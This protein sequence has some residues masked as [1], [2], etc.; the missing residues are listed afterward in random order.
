[1]QVEQLVLLQVLLQGGNG[2]CLPGSLGGLLHLHGFVAKEL[3][4]EQAE[5][6]KIM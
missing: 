1:M 4:L 2:R 6:K 3:N 5:I